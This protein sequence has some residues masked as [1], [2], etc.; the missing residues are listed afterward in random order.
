[1]VLESTSAGFSFHGSGCIDRLTTNPASPFHSL[2]RLNWREDSGRKGSIQIQM[3]MKTGAIRYVCVVR[4]LSTD[5]TAN[6][7]LY[8]CNSRDVKHE[9]MVSVGIHGTRF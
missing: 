9:Y 4:V 1:L 5:I 6:K 3:N 2:T 8:L 7:V